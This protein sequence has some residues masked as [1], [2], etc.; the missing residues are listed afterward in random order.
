MKIAMPDGCGIHVELQGHG[1]PAII[2]LHGIMMSGAVFKHQIGALAGDHRVITMDLR[3]FGQ[4]DKPET[5]YSGRIS[6]QT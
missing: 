5:G 6:S 2:F 3:G 1:E 4:S